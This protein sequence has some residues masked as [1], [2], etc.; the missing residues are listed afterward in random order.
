MSQ[1][2]LREQE[3]LRSVQKTDTRVHAVWGTG[4][5]YRGK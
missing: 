2:G 4:L 3:P 1:V 5:I